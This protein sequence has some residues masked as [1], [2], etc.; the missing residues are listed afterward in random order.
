MKQDGITE[1]G[2]SK[3]SSFDDAL[4]I[5]RI[6]MLLG[7]LILSSCQALVARKEVIKR[8]A[9]RQ[10]GALTHHHLS[11]NLVRRCITP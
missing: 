7:G 1:K 10:Q 4:A 5:V 3:A 2:W 8:N 6:G 11:F 9:Q